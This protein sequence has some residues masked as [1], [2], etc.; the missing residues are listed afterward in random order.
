MTLS[1]LTAGSDPPA[2]TEVTVLAFPSRFAPADAASSAQE[3]SLGVV[4]LGDE[5]VEILND[6]IEA[7]G[8][9]A[10]P[11]RNDRLSDSYPRTVQAAWP[12][13][14]GGLLIGWSL[15]VRA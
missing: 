3:P 9:P 6:E 11:R 7:A 8:W 2:Y 15:W 1:R 14:D 5:R 12:V 4:M 10:P 13:Y